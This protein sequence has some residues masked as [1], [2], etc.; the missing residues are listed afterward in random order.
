MIINLA[1]GGTNGY[2][3]DGVDGKCWVDKSERAAGE[4]YDNKAAWFNT[5]G[6]DSIFQIDSVK[7]WDLDGQKG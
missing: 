4:F 3:K 5:W 2:F 7:V 1:I 6:K